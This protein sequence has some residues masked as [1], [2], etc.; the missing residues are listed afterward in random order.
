MSRRKLKDIEFPKEMDAW[1]KE[2]YTEVLFVILLEQAEAML[3]AGAVY[4]F[5]EMLCA[6]N[7]IETTTI[8]QL[9]RD[10]MN[11]R[12]G[13]WVPSDNE[14]FMWLCR[15]GYDYKTVRKFAGASR[16]KLYYNLKKYLEL[17]VGNSAITKKLP[18][19]KYEVLDKFMIAVYNLYN[20]TKVVRVWK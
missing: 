2:R 18:Q 10:I 12:L 19:N 16:N 7:N 14:K 15:G 1:E 11:Y 4:S 13:S 20:L 17:E 9:Y 5:I 3:G 6:M 8:K